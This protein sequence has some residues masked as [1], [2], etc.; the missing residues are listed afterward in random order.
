MDDS[1][2][3]EGVAGLAIDTT[4]VLRRTII[5]FSVLIILYMGNLINCKVRSCI[6]EEEIGREG[7]HLEN[8]TPAV[9]LAF[10]LQR[11]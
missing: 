2:I 3:G 4:D 5:K 1:L 6:K 10:C 7:L 9:S 8:T 11:I